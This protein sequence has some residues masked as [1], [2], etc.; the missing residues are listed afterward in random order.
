MKKIVTLTAL[1]TI[2]VASNA[3]AAGFHLREQSAAAMG[4]AFAGATAGAENASYAYYNVAGLT[5]Q[6]GTQINMGATYISPRAEAENVKWYDGSRGADVNNI[7]HA[8]WVP[9]GTISHQVDDKLT[10]GLSLNVPYG[11]ITKYD[12]EWAGSDH[13]ITSKLMSTTVT[14]MAAYKL[15]DKLS[16]GAGLQMQYINAR[17]TSSVYNPYAGGDIGN[18]GLKGDAF[19][20]G[21]Q[22][23]A[24]Y[25]FNENTRIGVNY[26]SEVNH[27]LK[28]DIKGASGTVSS[29][30][31]YLNQDISTRL[32]TPAMLSVGA[33]HQLNDKW[34]LMAEYQRVYWSSFENLDI[35]GVDT[36]SPNGYL[37]SRTKENWQD[38][39]FFALGASYQID[40]QW[41]L[42]LGIA[43]DQAAAKK[44]QRTPRIPDSD[45]TWYS[46]GLSYEY[47]DKLTFD[48]AYTYI[49]AKNASMDTN[50]TGNLSGR[51][52]TADYKN[53][54]KLF[55]LSLNYKF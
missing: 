25:E 49:Q 48:F 23:G 10:L 43:K 14:P 1:G 53:S 39:N 38:T 11:M 51:R 35:M 29:M 20:V 44:A 19:D 34:A 24:M 21:Y 33:Y 8:A 22:L 45:R 13:G 30:V 32:D 55:G 4:N 31:P 15:T 7:V 6:K 17:L 16:V 41:K 5:R 12:S 27:K 36:L 3:M 52:V 9:N 26:R 54:V 37:I 2:L 50:L 28:G 46:A 40:D 18:I 47:N 42:R